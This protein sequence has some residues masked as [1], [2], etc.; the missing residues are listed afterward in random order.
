MLSRKIFSE[1]EEHLKQRY[2]TVITGMR[3]V[4]K[5]TALKYLLD[6]VPHDNKLYLDLERIENRYIFQQNT[7]KDVQIELEIQGIDFEKPSVIALDEIQLV[8][9]ITSILKYFYDTYPVKFIVTGSSSFYLRNHFSESLAGRKHIF[10]MFP[11]DFMEFVQFR[12]TDSSVLER[13][14]FQPYQQGIYLKYKDLYEEYLRFG[15]FPEVVLA[16]NVK[17]KE[18][19]LKDVVNAYIELDI[20]LV[21]DFEVSG[22]LYKLIR[23]LAA[24]AGNTLDVSKIAAVL[25]MDRIK[26]AG[27]LD[28]L[29]KTYFIH[30]ISPYS[31]SVDREISK[32]K[33]IYL[34]DT[35]LLQQLAQVSSGQVFENQVY[36]QLARLG[37]VN[38]YQKKSG[39]EIDFIFRQNTACEAKETPHAGDLAVLNS[40]S[41]SLGLTERLLIGKHPPGVGFQEFIWAGVVF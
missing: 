32:R 30:T 10:E 33:K 21:A 1:L 11:L 8:P 36:L 22:T 17:E 41:T 15:G 5:S 6:K 9:Q 37:E 14:A 23:L 31:R 39:Q 18:M 7:Y 29:E 13:F 12:G 38:Y 16:N 28:L 19:T 20:R 24:R 2:I 3:R 4:G 40:R 26:T 27:Y 34:A 25:G 35:G